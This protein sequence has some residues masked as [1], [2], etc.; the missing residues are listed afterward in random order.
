MTLLGNIRNHAQL[1]Y[2]KCKVFRAVSGPLEIAR[3]YSEVYGCIETPIPLNLF[4]EMPR[5]LGAS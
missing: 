4:A 3:S 1:P 5:Y 2:C